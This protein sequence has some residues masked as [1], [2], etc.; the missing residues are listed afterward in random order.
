MEKKFSEIREFRES[1]KSTKHEIRSIK[2]PL[3]YV[4]LHGTVL[5]HL[6]L[7]QKFVGSKV[8]PFGRIFVI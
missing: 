3:C 6:S 8:N 2:G 1:E 4:C 7:I 5:A